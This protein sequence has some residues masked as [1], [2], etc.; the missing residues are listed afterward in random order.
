MDSE[1]KLNIEKWTLKLDD[2]IKNMI[3]LEKNFTF[4]LT[5]KSFYIYEK[6]KDS[7]NQIGI[8]SSDKNINT[9]GVKYDTSRIWCDKNGIHVIFKLDRIAYYYNNF[10]QDKKIIK[11]LKLEYDNDYIEPFSFAFN[12]NNQ[13]HKNTD[14]ILFSDYNSCIYTLNIKVEDNGEIHE[15]INK[16]F[17]FRYINSELYINNQSEDAKEKEK[18]ERLNDLLESNHFKIEKDDRIMDMKLFYHEEKIGTGKKAVINKSYFILAVS[19]RIIFQFT[20][21][22]SL[23]EVFSKY[24]TENNEINDDELLKNCKIFPKINKINLEKTRIQTFTSKDRKP[25]FY[26]NNEC[27]F[28]MW[29]LIG[30]PVPLPQKEFNLYN[31]VKLKNDGTYEKKPIPV[32][33]CQTQYCIYFLYNDCLIIQSTLTNNIIHV[34]NLKENYLDIYYNSEMDK[35]ILYSNNDIIKISL[36]HEYNNLWKNYIERGEFDLALTTFSLEDENLRAKIFKLNGDLL[37]E[38]KD[39]DSSA[40]YYAL[41]DENFE[42]VCLKFMKLKN[43]NPLINYLNFFNQYKLSDDGKNK[44]NKEKYFI[45]KYLINTWL[46]E[47]N[48]EKEDI[49]ENK[50]KDKNENKKDLRSILFGNDAIESNKYIDKRIISNFLQYYGRYKDYTDFAGMKNDYQA[51]IFDLVNHSKYKEAIS[52]L[53]VY[54]SYSTDD[55]YL[56]NLINIFMTYINIFIK[57]SPKE[58]IELIS[59]YY[60]L[61][62]NPLDIIKIINNINIYDNDIF[63]ENFENILNL[64]KKL[65][66]VSKKNNNKNV[67]DNNNIVYDLGTKKG[68]YNL[69]IL[70]LTLSIKEAH[71]NELLNYFKSLVNQCYKSNNY[72]I[73]NN[74]DQILFDFTFAEKILISKSA[75]AL[76]Y[77]LKKEYNKSI[78]ISLDYE[79]KNTSIFIA[80]SISDPKLKKEI[81]LQI[82]NHFKSSDIDIIEEIL[83]KS[84]GVLKILD[85]LP[86]L[87]GNVHLKDIKNDL[88][89]SV[90]SYESNLKKLKDKIKDYGKSVDLLSREINTISNNRQNSLRFKFEGIYCA[91]CLKNLKELNFY[92]YPCRHAFDFD[93]LM[94]T[95]FY[96]DTKKIGD[97]YFM[98][99]MLGIKQLINEIKELNLRKKNNLERRNT[100]AQNHK[101]QNVVTGF[102]KNLTLRNNNYDILDSYKQEEKEENQLLDLENALDKLLTQECP[103]CGNEMILSTQIKFGDEDTNDW[104]V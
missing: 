59:K 81:W 46:V 3:S 56:K 83:N 104:N 51:I 39:Y 26:W 65:I 37:F 100:I 14:E 12:N 64:I 98:K 92:L 16:V 33:C 21:I 2:K 85:I 57:E 36:D 34:E 60:Y 88:I 30:T 50:Q 62:E 54:I 76:L 43:I 40:N 93:C 72:Y 7:L 17:D 74:D 9:L 49:E 47:L 41:S 53:L 15:K 101:K 42:H 71:L 75:I 61:I 10:L 90:N 31:Y 79:D 91:I 55:N 24:K 35:L 58:V 25:S 103:L 84:G 78:S 95:L 77:C 86:H 102:F 6:T 22:N 44:K 73:N 94:N 38:K 45:Q 52:N 20:G 97:D 67:K 32:M 13:N 19:K 1:D 80:N 18:E 63:E 69:Y 82:F 99:K 96:F 5:N 28:C 70:Y 11:E 89:S 29:K 23:S 27:G 4:I 66:D 48:L 87:M 8:P 68:L